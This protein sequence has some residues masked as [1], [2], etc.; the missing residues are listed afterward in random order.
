MSWRNILKN[1]WERALSIRQ[2]F[3]RRR[4]KILRFGLFD[5]NRADKNSYLFR[6]IEF[7]HKNSSTCDVRSSNALHNIWCRCQYTRQE[8]VSLKAEHIW[9]S[10][11]S[12]PLKQINKQMSF[13]AIANLI[14]KLA[15]IAIEQS[16]VVSETRLMS[17]PQI[18]CNQFIV[19][20]DTTALCRSIFH[21]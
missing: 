2:V 7:L 4:N 19:H 15:A 5:N 8:K 17:V 14:A 3:V 11:N 21:H 18:R 1:N 6:F 12:T 9:F 16:F 20:R 13:G 10:P